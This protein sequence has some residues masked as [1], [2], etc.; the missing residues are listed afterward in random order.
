MDGVILNYSRRQFRKNSF[1]RPVVFLC[2]FLVS[3]ITRADIL[4]LLSSDVS[5]YQNTAESLKT[6]A[7]TL[8]IPQS[9]FTTLTV[10][11]WQN[12][13][14][15][16][17]NQQ[18]YALIVTIG[19]AAADEAV[20]Q[21]TNTPLLNI[22]IPKNAFETIYA[23]RPNRSREISAIYLDQPLQRL[24]RLAVILKPQA[25]RFGAV[26]GPISKST[27]PEISQLITEHGAHLSYSLLG[28]D[29]NPVAVLRPIVAE[30][31]LFIAIPDHA[32]F[33]KA[34]A[35]WILYLSFQQKIPVI[36]FSRA[37][38][39]AGAIASVFSSPDNVG[40]HAA[41]LITDKL[42]NE[43]KEISPPQYPRYFTISTNPAV[44]RSMNIPLPLEKELYAK[45]LEQDALK[46]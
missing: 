46:P 9:F 12:Q 17:S 1:L 5:Y 6:R 3:I 23:G 10:D 29:E 30:S 22:F 15:S 33:N 32:I 36:G 27:Q 37:Y 43:N 31:D 14:G 26:F 16:R 11:Q 19:T 24:V 21:D 4:L 44:A 40:R 39:N 45:L 35:R 8:G 25:K 13:G 42:E 34:I 28:E 2:L 38:T 18:P 41:E 20:K 7:S